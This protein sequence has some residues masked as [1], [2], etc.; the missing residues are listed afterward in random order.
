MGNRR[1]FAREKLFTHKSILVMVVTISAMSG[2]SSGMKTSKRHYVSLPDGKSRATYILTTNIASYRIYQCSFLSYIILSNPIKSS[3][4][5]NSRNRQFFQTH[6]APTFEPLSEGE[7]IGDKIQP[8]QS[9]IPNNARISA[10][11]HGWDIGHQ[12]SIA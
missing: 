3:N 4:L 2:Y 10:S 6:Q 1:T 8:L 5:I 12:P 11:S 9:E 7:T